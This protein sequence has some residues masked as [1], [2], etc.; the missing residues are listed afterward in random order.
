M[1]SVNSPTFK[2]VYSTT[3]N[4]VLGRYVE[5]GEIP[6]GCAVGE[7]TNLIEDFQF[8]SY[9]PSLK[10][11]DLIESL[12]EKF[13]V[14]DKRRKKREVDYLLH[15]ALAKPIEL[16]GTYWDVDG[17][18]LLTITSWLQTL[19]HLTLLPENFGWRDANNELHPFSSVADL[20]SFLQRLL[21]KTKA[22]EFDFIQRA[23]DEKK[24]IEEHQTYEQLK[25]YAC[26]VSFDEAVE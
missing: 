8:C 4:T 2:I 10:R 5:G 19:Q 18:S 12:V 23:W 1:E 6:S 7:S 20:E 9:S 13:T 16:D 11:M 17:K 3:N 21:A 22:R 25:T 24:R 15:T 26:S 14:F